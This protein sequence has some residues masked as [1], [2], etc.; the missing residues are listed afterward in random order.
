MVLGFSAISNVSGQCMVLT[1]PSDITVG[2]DPGSCEATIAPG[3]L[4]GSF[5][6]SCA[7]VALLPVEDFESLCGDGVTNDL[8]AGWFLD[9]G[10]APGGSTT[11]T[12]I[13]T[14]GATLG[15]GLYSCAANNGG[16]Q[17]GGT[18]PAGFSGNVLSMED[19]SANDAPGC[20]NLWG[21]GCVYAPV[22]PN[23][24]SL[25]LSWQSEAFAGLGSFTID[26]WDGAAWN[27]IV[28]TTEDTDS[29]E[30]DNQTATD[31]GG[32]FPAGDPDTFDLLCYSNPDFQVRF[33]FDDEG[34]NGW[35]AAIDNVQ[36]GQLAAGQALADI[37]IDGV[38]VGQSLTPDAAGTYAKGD[39]TVSFIAYD[40]TG[41]AVNCD[42]TITV[43]DQEPPG[44]ITC[45]ADIT[46]NI[47]AGECGAVVDYV[48]PAANGDNCPLEASPATSLSLNAAF[49][50]ASSVNSVA[51]GATPSEHFQVYPPLAQDMPVN[52]VDI[53]VSQFTA[54]GP[55]TVNIYS[56]GF[57]PAG[58]DFLYADLTLLGT[59]SATAPGALG[60]LNIPLT[61]TVPA[62]TNYV[63]SV[64]NPAGPNFL[65][66]YDGGSPG[67]T[68]YAT[69]IG[70]AGFDEPSA[71]DNLVGIDDDVMLQVNFDAVPLVPT[72]TSGFA[73]G[74][75]FPIG[76]TEV[77]YELE[78]CGGNVVECCF[79][80]IVNPFPD[81]TSVLACNDLVNISLDETCEAIIT[82]DMMLEGGPYYCYDN[83]TVQ[84][85]DSGTGGNSVTVDETYLGQTIC[86]EVC[87][88]LTGN[89]C[90]GEV[91]IEDKIAPVIA[92]EDITVGC[93]AT[94][95]S[96]GAL[97]SPA[98][99]YPTAADAST[100][101]TITTGA[102][103]LVEIPVSGLGNVTDVDV[104]LDIDHTWVGDLDITLT[105]PSGTSVDILSNPGGPGFGCDQ[106]NINVVMDDESANAYAAFDGTCETCA[107]P[108]CYAIEGDFQPMSPLSAFDGEPSNGVW[109]LEIGDLVGG[110][111]GMPTAISLNLS[112]DTYS[113]PDEPAILDPMSCGD[114]YTV[115]YV[116]SE[117][118]QDCTNPDYANIVTRTWTVVDGYGNSTSCVSTIFVL[119]RGLDDVV[120]PPNYDGIDQPVLACDGIGWDL[121]FNG[122]P[123]PNETGEPG[124]A[125]C[126]NIQFAPPEDVVIP[127]CGD[128]YKIVRKWTILDW[129]TGEVLEHNQLIKVAGQTFT[130]DAGPDLFTSTDVWGCTGTIQVPVYTTSYSCGDNSTNEIV[131]VTS[132][133]GTPTLGSNGVWYVT[134]I[135][136]GVCTVTITIDDGCGNT[137]SDDFDVTVEDLVPPTAI[138]DEHTIVSLTVDNTDPA[139]PVGTAKVFATNLDDGSYDNCGAIWYKV[140]R[141]DIGAC[142]GANGDD[143]PSVPG[144]QEM[145]DDWAFYCCEDDVVMT[146]F[147]VY[148][149][150]PGDGPVADSRHQPGGDL[151]GHFNDAMVEVEVQD[152]LAPYIV[153]PADVTLDCGDELGDLADVDNPY[154]GSPTVSDNCT[155]EVTVNVEDNS[156]CG[157]S[158]LLTNGTYAYAYKRTFVAS[159]ANGSSTCTQLIYIID[160]DPF[161]GNDIDYPNDIDVGCA[162]D[163][164]PSSTGEPDFNEDNCSLIAVAYDDQLFQYVD[165]VCAKILRTWTIIDWCVFDPDNPFSGGIWSH[166]QVIKV[167]N[168]VA[169]EITGGCPD[170]PI[171]V[172]SYDEDCQAADVVLTIEATDDCDTELQYSY[173]IDAFSDGGCDISGNTND[174]SG[175]YPIGTHEITWSVEDGCGNIT[176]CTYT[177]IIADCKKPTPVCINGLST[178][179]MPSTGE[180]QIWANDF[181]SGSSFDNCTAYEDLQFSF[182]EDVNDTG[183]TLTC[184]NLGSTEVN[185]WVTDEFG[186]QDFCTTYIILTDNDSTCN[187]ISFAT[188]GGMVQTEEVENV[189]D[190]T[191]EL[192]NSG[193]GMS[194]YVTSNNGLY[195]FPNLNMNSQYTVSPERDDDYLNGV[196]TLD[197]VKIQKHLLGIEPLASPY[198]RIAADAN[199]SESISAIDI[200]ELRKLILG[201]TNDLP[202]NDSWRFV[203]KAHTFANPNNPWPFPES[204]SFAPLMTNE[205]TED[206]V[207][208]KIG[209]VNGTASAS[210]LIALEDRGSDAVSI[211][212]K[213]QAVKAGDV[214]SIDVTSEGFD[215]IVGYQFTMNLGSLV[216]EGVEGVGV[217]VSDANFG[218]LGNGILTTSW[219]SL[220]GATT[221]V[222]DNSVLYRITVRATQSGMLSDMLAVNSDITPAEAYT[223]SDVINDVTLKVTSETAVSTTTEYALYQNQPNPFE[224]MTKI[225]FNMANEGSAT[226]TVYDVTGKVITTIDGDYVKGYNEIELSRNDVPASGVLYYQLSAEEFTATKKMIT[227]K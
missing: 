219:S 45:P 142:D 59:G 119:R 27:N 111:D 106:N 5:T 215:N 129:C 77:C 166:T 12:G 217:Q 127:I 218:N 140:R 165:G 8:P 224:S 16:G 3:V 153:C 174:A 161:D 190:V 110:D 117:D 89:C 188:I 6:G 132:T 181:E 187:G 182:S 90:W 85:C 112:T 65:A 53:V 213:D 15:C 63:V 216:Y 179:V 134:D 10:T 84:I 42:F 102:P 184:D 226:L 73:S 38:L 156:Q 203:E 151:F 1:C 69:C 118:P 139:N 70:L 114:D 204:V 40:V 158:I 227:V 55:V 71:V 176:T 49:G 169:P 81:T 133:C 173:C 97:V 74:E 83:Y 191:M 222:Q 104:N 35:G 108:G 125:Y 115:T 58:D 92:C 60:L 41:A 93:E 177:F 154:L 138:A 135:P 51:C 185:I 128:S 14:D 220:D 100:F 30:D 86:I 37:I 31:C 48:P 82:A 87:D 126:D 62:N 212:I 95:L 131:T 23:G 19:D 150:D 101:G 149:V 64:I 183:L 192:T 88:P 202:N 137:A 79:N 98:G 164:D 123:D 197:L 28:T 46:A 167:T 198:K 29:G 193:S 194:T 18:P 178:V 44:A 189:T 36:F 43:E 201:I 75:V 2:T 7:G 11:G 195:I 91:L 25:S 155:Y 120:V 168:G 205:I 130:V 148:D 116:D 223:S 20:N 13:T 196:T 144:Y 143:F 78:D 206:F 72:L 214:I 34:T 66:G 175:A 159:D 99:T 200:I 17:T 107:A 146:I 52:S 152:K 162:S 186:N 50:T 121:N 157:K 68:T 113:I 211:V 22:V 208:I 56:I 61:T 67:V 225:G 122:Y 136:G 21:F 103:L 76:A 147:R 80:V 160:T 39:H 199:N 47:S 141:M 221:K 54:G 9:D 171:E 170:G 32:N 94:D 172:C 24:A 96:P 4:T 105:S 26:V 180:V 163:T 109:I 57:D 145:F 33:C 124:G 207:G 209:D 210:S